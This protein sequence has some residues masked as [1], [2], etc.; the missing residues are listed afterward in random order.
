[1]LTDPTGL[2]LG[3]GPYFLIYSRAMSPEEEAE[4]LDWPA[5]IKVR[6]RRSLLLH[7][8]SR[9]TTPPCAQNSVKHNN[10]AFFAHL[11]PNLVSR[12]V[13]RN[14][15]PSSPVFPPTRSEHTISSDIVDPPS[16]DELMDTTD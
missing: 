1:M 16:R 3:A 13:H 12:L 7:P 10:K 14:L 8:R 5:D 2:H 15:A 4:H 9:L 6:L 11:P